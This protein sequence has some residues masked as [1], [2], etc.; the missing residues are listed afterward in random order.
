MGIF[1]SGIIRS[2]N[3]IYIFNCSCFIFEHHNKADK[4]LPKKGIHFSALML[5]YT[6]NH[7]KPLQSDFEC[8]VVLAVSV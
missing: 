3:T 2:A 5:L 7:G 6:R 1:R 8:D 4:S